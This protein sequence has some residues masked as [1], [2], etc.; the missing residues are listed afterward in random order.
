MPH[1]PQL[2][3]TQLPREHPPVLS[4]QAG[5]AQRR[6]RNKAAG[7]HSAVALRPVTPAAHW[8]RPGMGMPASQRSSSSVDLLLA[9][10]G[11]ERECAAVGLAAAHALLCTSDCSSLVM[12]CGEVGGARSARA[13]LSYTGPNADAGSHTYTHSHSSTSRQ[14]CTLHLG[15]CSACLCLQPCVCTSLP[16]RRVGTADGHHHGEGVFTTV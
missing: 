6:T 15:P 11:A 7:I 2:R 9:A 3:S 14:P 4:T 5:D 8:A 12:L 1:A 13:S 16:L 10:A